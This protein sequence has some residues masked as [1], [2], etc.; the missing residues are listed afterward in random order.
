MNVSRKPGFGP[1]TGDDPVHHMAMHVRIAVLGIALLVSSARADQWVTPTEHTVVSPNR[2]LQA[3]ITPAKDGKSGATATIGEKDKAGKS[4][5]LATR[6]MPVDVVLFDDGSLLAL[7]HWHQLGYGKVATMYER[8]GTIRWTKTLVE[9]IGQALVDSAQ[10]SVSS[11]WWRKMPLE[12][13]FA[14]D[15]KSVRVTLF[16]EDH[17]QL[18]LRDGATAIVAVTNLPDDPQRMLNRARA[19]AA[20][21]GREP[22]AVTLLERI[23]AK[24]ADQL[25]AVSLFIEVLQRMNEHARAAA[26][27][28]HASKRWKAKDGYSLANVCVA[29]AKS[30]RELSRNADAERVLQMGVIAAPTYV[31]PAISLATLLVDEQRRKDADVVLDALV[32][33]L[34]KQ[35]HLD[36]HSLSS[37]ADFY[38]QRGER[39]KALALYLKGY[40][41]DQVTNQFLYAELAK[42]YEEMGDIPAAIR[43]HEQ[44]LDHFVKM[45]SA[46]DTYTTNTRTEIARL[47]AKRP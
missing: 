29:W 3:V 39:A 11:I 21:P 40:Q 20:R 8:D 33:R 43:V 28:E 27:V 6:W 13:S 7:D 12:W 17:L 45:G 42:L 4:F 47:K 35:S 46:F 16:D 15:R 18:G 37:V 10:H 5:M 41:K 36:S 26:G 44:L 9:L 38:K 30:L 1:C 2:K 23:I 14:K 22:A 34:L 31:N 32:G 25:E 24:D 19:L